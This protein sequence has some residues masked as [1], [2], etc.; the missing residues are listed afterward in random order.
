MNIL[1]M[2][3]N[4]L[5]N[6]SIGIVLLMANIFCMFSVDKYS[7]K[8]KFFDSLDARLKAKYIKI[9]EERRRIYYRGFV[10]GIL[11]SIISVGSLY[12]QNNKISNKIIICTTLGI[13]FLSNYFYY[14]LSPKSDWMVLHLNSKYQREEWLKIYRTMSVRFHLG[15]LLGLLAVSFL[16]NGSCSYLKK[17][18]KRA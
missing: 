5:I 14:I 8:Q 18:P 16:S 4:C 10:M 3:Q 7:I 12:S 15:F 13:T 2:L 9:I 17:R 6:C 11:L 1:Y